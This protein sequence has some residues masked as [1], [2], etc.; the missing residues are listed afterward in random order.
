MNVASIVGQ[1]GLPQFSGYAASKAGLIGLTKAVAV[2]LSDR[3][4]R[5]NA[6]CPGFVI[7]SY[8]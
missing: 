2:E 8:A 3:N 7:T 6:V 5:I 4:I 1:R